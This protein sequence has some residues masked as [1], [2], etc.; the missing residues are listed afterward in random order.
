M[1]RATGADSAM[2]YV[3][4]V[5]TD[6]FLDGTLV[7]NECLRL[8]RS[9]YQLHVVVGSNVGVTVR[10]ALARAGIARI[11]A[12]PLA[13]PGYILSANEESDHHKHWSGVF[14]KLHVFSLCQFEKIVYIDSDVLV[15]RNIDDLFDKPHMS[16]TVAGSLPG[17]EDSSDFST[18]LMVI[19]PAPGLTS[20]LVALLPEAFEREK[21]WR[22]EA[23]RPMSMGVQGVINY[24]WSE[25]MAQDDRHLHASYNVMAT[26]LDYYLKHLGYRL[27]G[28]DAIRVLHFDGEVKPWMTTGVGFCRRAG[29][30]VRRGR[31]W[32]LAALVAFKAVLQSARLRLALTR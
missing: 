19:E 25:W 21:T 30:L 2:A 8:C 24:F 23:G 3:A 9:K 15:I 18:G 6:D 7:L 28:P 12:E 26:H 10:E 22:A 20:E 4:V 11:Q 31:V 27:R 29:G 17:R 16:A 13:I 32:E 14:D 5:S 1:T